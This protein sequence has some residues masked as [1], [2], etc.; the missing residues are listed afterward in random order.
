MLCQR[1]ALAEGTSVRSFKSSDGEDRS[2][3]FV[4]AF[5]VSWRLEG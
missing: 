4:V 3:L 1:P 2:K 5:G